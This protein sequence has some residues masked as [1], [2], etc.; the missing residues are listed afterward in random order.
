MQRTVIIRRV[1]FVEAGFNQLIDKPAIDSFV[2]VRR[3]DAEQ[4]N[5]RNAAIPM[6]IQG[7]QSLSVNARRQVSK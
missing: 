4:K 5:R 7:V 2:E 1:V 3:L 6:M